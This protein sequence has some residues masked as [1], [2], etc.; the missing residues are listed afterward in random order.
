[1][2]RMTSLTLVFI[3]LIGV[4]VLTL[5][6]AEPRVMSVQIK[7]GQVRTAPAYLGKIVTTLAYAQQVTVLEE[8]GDW[9]K[10]Q[11][12]GSQTEGW[13]H[14]SALTRKKIVLDADAA[15]VA[16]TATSDEVALAGKGIFSAEV[17]EQYKA[18]HSDVNYDI[19]NAMENVVISQSQI[20]TFLKEGEI[21][22][23]GGRQ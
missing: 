23:E 9:L 21:S 10:V 19:V 2:R 7:E 11:P 22:P 12:T 16:K 4:S 13:M 15:D 1:M 20:L 8:K 18:G 3:V 5:G 6:A 14:T 17:E